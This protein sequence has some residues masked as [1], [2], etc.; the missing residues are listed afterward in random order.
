MNDDSHAESDQSATA[1]SGGTTIFNDYVSSNTRSL[2]NAI[3]DPNLKDLP[4]TLSAS[5]VQNTVT[6]CVTRIENSA[7]CYAG[8]N[9]REI[10]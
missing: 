2:T 10:R 4:L 1:I 3:P 9:W 5:G 8:F 6:I 7:N